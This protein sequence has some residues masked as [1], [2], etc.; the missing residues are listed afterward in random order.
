LKAIWKRELQSYFYTPVG[1]VF[2]GV[3]LLISSILFYLSILR[4]HS[5]DLPTFLGQMSYLWMLLSPVLTMRLLAEERQKRTDQLLVTSPVSQ[6]SIVLGKYLAAVTVLLITAGATLLYAALVA[7]YGKI[8]PAE[9]AVNYLGFLL[10]GCAFVALDLFVS[11]CAGTPVTAA[12]LAF[13]ANFLIWMTDL[14]QDQIPIPALADVLRF[15]S[16]YRWNEA[17]LMGQFSWAGV[18]FMLSFIAVFLALT[19]AMLR[20]R[21]EHLRR[22][23]PRAALLLGMTAALTVGCAAIS[24][25]EKSNGWR[26][27]YSFNGITTQSEATRRAVSSLTRPVHI[28][29]MFSKG[30]EDAPLMELLD[31]YQASS[32][33]ITWEQADPGLNPALV[34]RFSR[35]DDPVTMDS[36]IVFCEETGRWRILSPTDFVTLSMDEASG[37]YTYAGYSYERAITSALLFVTREKI[38][39]VV[40]LQG[41]GELDGETLHAFD[42]FLTQNHYEVVYQ[43]LSAAEYVP[44]PSELLVFFSPM[45]DLSQEELARLQRYLDQGGK[46]LLTCDYTDPVDQMPNYASLLRSFGFLPR[47]GIVIADREDPDSYYN[48]MRVHLIPRMLLTNITADLVASGADTVLLPGCRAFEAPGETDRNLTVLPVL[49]SGDTA[50]LK[51]LSSGMTNVEKAEGD[52]TGPFVLALQAQRVTEAG[53]IC[54]AFILGS[55]GML[56]EEQIYAM[57]DVQQL[58]IRILEYLTGESS[59]SLDIMTRSAVRPGLSARSNTLGSFLVTM[60]P[61]CVLFAAL[62]VLLRRKNL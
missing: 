22:F 20:R 21:R 34:T 1:Y 23:T 46:L 5:G 25:L 62:A 59:I 60:L 17:F 51:K 2:L 33:L 53:N 19:D 45:R 24:S 12:F 32:P 7:V 61:V 38:P 6:F 9:L 42:R 48:Q 58:M 4:Q 40:L 30:Q 10:Q 15:L 3:F 39:R 27:D 44:D 56:T 41:H 18:A 55:S 35:T 31:R 28:Y 36:L 43:D 57:T 8:Y 11:G 26:L 49:Q 54:R 37:T 16:L 50:Y 14:I 52:E 47:E 29:A 13:G